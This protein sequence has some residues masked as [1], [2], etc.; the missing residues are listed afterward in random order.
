MIAATQ[1]TVVS[2]TASATYGNWWVVSINIDAGN[3]ANVQALV[4]MRKCFPNPDGSPNYS[5]VDPVVQFVV[6][7]LLQDPDPTVQTAVS[8]LLSAVAI[9]AAALNLL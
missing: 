4:S 5:P 8:T 2:S 6:P 1:P 9:K 7:Q 3:A